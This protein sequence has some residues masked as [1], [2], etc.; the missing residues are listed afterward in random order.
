MIT[1]LEFTYQQAR[2]IWIK[3]GCAANRWLQIDEN[4]KEFTTFCCASLAGEKSVIV[5][6]K[7]IDMLID[8]YKRLGYKEVRWN[9]AT[10]EY[11]EVK[12]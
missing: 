3:N 6:S 1:T 2:R 4:N 12:H 8:H 10:S 11:E 9:P 5:S 7:S